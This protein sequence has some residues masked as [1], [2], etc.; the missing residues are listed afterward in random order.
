M[1]GTCKSSP[2][3]IQVGFKTGLCIKMFQQTSNGS[4]LWPNFS[5]RPNTFRREKVEL[6]AKLEAKEEII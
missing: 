3:L 5:K 4:K 1:T 6:E 2:R